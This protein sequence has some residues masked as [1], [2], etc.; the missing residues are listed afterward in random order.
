MPTLSLP[1]PD[2][3]A[4]PWHS[5]PEQLPPVMSDRTSQALGELVLIRCC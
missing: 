1:P 2:R 5:A 3:H 4:K